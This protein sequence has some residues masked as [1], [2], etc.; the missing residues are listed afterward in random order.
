MAAILNG[1]AIQINASM[2]GGGGKDLG[3]LT[4]LQDDALYNK[5]YQELSGKNM[6]VSFEHEGFLS[7]T[8]EGLGNG[9]FIAYVSGDYN[10]YLIY[11]G[12]TYR[13]TA[14][15]NSFIT[16]LISGATYDEASGTLIFNID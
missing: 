13:A 10:L 15:P 5:L 1:K 7:S 6:F 8:N 14:S 2:S 3:F 4:D 11:E 16:T 12:S 9:R